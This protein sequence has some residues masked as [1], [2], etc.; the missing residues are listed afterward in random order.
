MLTNKPCWCRIFLTSRS[1]IALHRTML[2]LEAQPGVIA[3]GTEAVALVRTLGEFFVL[4]AT[5]TELASLAAVA[6]DIATRNGSTIPTCKAPVWTGAIREVKFR[7][8]RKFV[9]IET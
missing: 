3:D 4:S 5:D 7:S 9:M 6:R 1:R 2:L 8:W